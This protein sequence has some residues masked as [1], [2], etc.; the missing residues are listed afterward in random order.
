ML[1]NWFWAV[2]SLFPSTFISIMAWNLEKLINIINYSINYE[3]VYI[4]NTLNSFKI[5]KNNN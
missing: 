5:V 2:A 1:Q 4:L 3:Q